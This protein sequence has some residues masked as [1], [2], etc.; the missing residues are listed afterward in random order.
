MVHCI[1]IILVTEVVGARFATPPVCTWFDDDKYCIDTYS[2]QPLGNPSKTF[3][4]ELTNLKPQL[5]SSRQRLKDDYD[6]FVS[7]WTPVTRIPG[8]CR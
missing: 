1:E 5:V 6:A 7:T 8:E 2:V 4:L 3:R